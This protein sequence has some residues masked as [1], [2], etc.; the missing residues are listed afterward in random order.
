MPNVWEDPEYVK[1]EGAKQGKFLKV[2]DLISTRILK[3]TV[4]NHQ[5]QDENTPPEAKSA[6]GM[7]WNYYFEDLTDDTPMERVHSPYAGKPSSAFTISMKMANIQPG[8]VFT[9]TAT[10]TG[11]DSRVDIVKLSTPQ[12]VEEAKLKANKEVA[13]VDVKSIPF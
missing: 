1:A 11:K 13:G 2:K 7:Q 3:F 5:L 10:G 4:R 9:A 8:D 12:A 6:D